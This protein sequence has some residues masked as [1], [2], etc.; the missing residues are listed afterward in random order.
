MNRTEICKIDVLLTQKRII[1]QVK[2][3]YSMV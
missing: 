3:L 1:G 2:S